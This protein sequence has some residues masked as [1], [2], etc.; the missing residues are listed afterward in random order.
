MWQLANSDGEVDVTVT[1]QEMSSVLDGL[2]DDILTDN[3][4]DM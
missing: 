2:T 3:V 4:P 1:Q